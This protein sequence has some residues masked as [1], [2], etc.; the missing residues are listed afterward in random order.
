M[1]SRDTFYSVCRKQENANPKTK[2]K[3]KT[4]DGQL[5]KI[6]SPIMYFTYAQ[7]HPDRIGSE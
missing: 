1:R 4:F 3:A 2:K 7:M 6:M 5:V